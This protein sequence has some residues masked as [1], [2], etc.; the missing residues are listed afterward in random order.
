MLSG[1]G[2]WLL[3]GHPRPMAETLHPATPW[4]L[5]EQLQDPHADRL[6]PLKQGLKAES[7]DKFTGR[8]FTSVELG[9]YLLWALP[10]DQAPL[11]YGQVQLFPL[12]HWQACQQVL[13]AAGDWESALS[14]M[15]ATMIFVDAEQHPELR[16]QLLLPEH[17]SH[18]RILLDETGDER[19]PDPR[20]RW[21][22]A[23]RV[24]K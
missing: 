7:R 24:K 11:L 18:W 2:L 5:A 19:K 17:R 9:D 4:Q 23:V 14:Q 15:N 8:I 22:L 3:H 12:S 1:A 21:L 20:T 16:R 13:A 10:A 6:P